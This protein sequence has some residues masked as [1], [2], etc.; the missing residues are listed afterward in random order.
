MEEHKRDMILYRA[1]DELYRS[2]SDLDSIDVDFEK[3]A[4]LIYRSLRK[5]NKK[6]GMLISEL[7][8]CLSNE[9]DK[10]EKLVAKIPE[11]YQYCEP[12]IPE[13]LSNYELPKIPETLPNLLK[14]PETL[15]YC[16][17]GE[18]LVTQIDFDRY[19]LVENNFVVDS[20]AKFIGIYIDQ[21]S[22][23]KPFCIRQANDDEKKE[24]SLLGL[25]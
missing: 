20:L 4:D 24:A 5:D 25:K 7:A 3:I 15:Q 2:V 1:T 22:L 19:K 13:R 10:K 6:I 14:I 23:G 11:T 16:D 21:A 17:P 9:T 18:L 8:K 12:K